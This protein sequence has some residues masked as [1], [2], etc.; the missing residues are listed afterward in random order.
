VQANNPVNFTV[1]FHPRA[2]T[3]TFRATLNPN[4]GY[5]T[6]GGTDITSSFSQ[7]F[8][9]GG[10]TTAAVI[11]PPTGRIIPLTGGIQ[12]HRLRVEAALSPG[13][14]FEST[15]HEHLFR[16]SGATTPPPPPPPSSPGISL[17]AMPAQQTVEWG[18]G[19][20]YQITLQGQNNFNG[21]VSVELRGSN[22]N[23]LP[24][25][26]TSSPVSVMLTPQSSSATA[27]LNL[28]TVAVATQPG[29]L[30]LQVRAS[31]AGVTTRTRNVTLNVTRTPGVF[32]HQPTISSATA[33]CGN[34][35]A[36]AALQNIGTAL[37]P[38]YRVTFSVPPANSTSGIPAIFYLF[39]PAPAC[40]G[41]ALHPLTGVTGG[42]VP[43]ALS[44]YNLGFSQNLGAPAIPGRIANRI[45]NWHQFWFSQDQS[46]LLLATKLPL[47]NPADPQS[48]R[49][50]LYDAATGRELANGD[51]LPRSVGT[52]A[53]PIADIC[54]VEL[55]SA[56]DTVTATYRNRLNQPATC[57]FSANRTGCQTGAPQNCDVSTRNLTF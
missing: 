35:L 51:I 34:N 25:G 42:A 55:N 33:T 53:D 22:N 12:E 43:P 20:T 3:G 10:Q 9:P 6:T 57:P 5:P 17:S 32:T 36:S 31:S 19:T 56:G 24:P 27:T 23:P 11:V 26:V 50:F 28:S 54:R 21:T 4:A 15:G 49:L 16:L 40:I 30:T 45:V 13:R 37:N 41:V 47:Q 2:V 44:W 18:N 8:T 7:P 48:Y 14:V 52:T 46:L 39:S 38:D 1:E 29:A